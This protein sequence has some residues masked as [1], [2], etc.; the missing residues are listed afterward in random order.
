MLTPD[1]IT[2][3]F[4][5]IDDLLIGLKH[6]EDKRPSVSD[7]EMAI[8]AIV[9]SL[10]FGGNQYHP[11]HFMKSHGYIPKMLDTSRFN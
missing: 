11:I 10:Y 4:C 5:L 7:S 1:K 3:I 2:A 9:S 6:Q 8:T